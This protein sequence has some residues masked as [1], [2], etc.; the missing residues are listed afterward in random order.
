MGKVFER[1]KDT[2]DDGSAGGTEE[3]LL[4]KSALDLCFA[5]GGGLIRLTL[6]YLAI[7]VYC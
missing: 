6:A 3:Y 5:V 7:T 4:V 1:G 2:A